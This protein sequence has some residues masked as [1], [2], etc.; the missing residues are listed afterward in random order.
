MDYHKIYIGVVSKYNQNGKNC[1]STKNRRRYMAKVQANNT[2]NNQPKRSRMSTNRTTHTKQLKKTIQTHRNTINNDHL[3]FPLER[4]W[5]TTSTK[6]PQSLF[7]V[8]THTI[9]TEVKKR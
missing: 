6:L 2:K 5:F 1:F 4:L 7:R 8:S 3:F 9:I